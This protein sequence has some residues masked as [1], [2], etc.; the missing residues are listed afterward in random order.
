MPGPATKLVAAQVHLEGDKLHIDQEGRSRKFANKVQQ[1]TFAASSAN[2][3]PIMYVTER[4]VFKLVEGRGLELVEIA[5]GVK[6][7]LHS[8]LLVGTVS[9]E[10]P[11]LRLALWSL[12]QPSML[13]AMP[14]LKHVQ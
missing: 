1:K 11:L 14:S 9:G 7:E 5:P 6:Q 4:A 12:R 8:C 10:V 2:G 3:R 13:S